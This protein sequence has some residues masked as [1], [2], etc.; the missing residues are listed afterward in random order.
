VDIGGIN[1][2]IPVN[3][4]DHGWIDDLLERYK[5]GE[6]IKVKVMELDKENERVVVSA[7]ALKPSPYPDCAKRYAPGGEYTGTVTGV[8]AY[9]VFVNLE[10]GVD[11]LV[12]HMKFERVKKGDRVLVRV[13]RVERKNLRQHCQEIVRGW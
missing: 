3:E 8:E 10:P 13:R 6:H 9:G 11:A 7:K 2:K 12:P 5:V 4:V 1:V